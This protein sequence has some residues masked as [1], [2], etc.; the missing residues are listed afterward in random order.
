MEAHMLKATEDRNL[1]ALAQA[2][3]QSAAMVPDP[4]W[5]QGENGWATIANDGATKA[6]ANDFA[7][8]R[9]SCKRCHTAWQ[10]RYRAEHRTRPV[11]TP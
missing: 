7:G 11:P 9:A 3:E 8:A 6:R 5:N 1:P 2:L 10:D 4:A